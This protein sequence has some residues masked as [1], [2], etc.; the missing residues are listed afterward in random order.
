MDELAT[1]RSAKSGSDNYLQE[2]FTKHTEITYRNIKELA[3]ILGISLAALC[4]RV[5]PGIKITNRY[6]WKKDG[7]PEK[8]WDKF[9]AEITAANNAAPQIT[10]SHTN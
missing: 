2:Q 9:R 7:V 6:G 1:T 3:E 8:Y 4:E 5:M 10:F